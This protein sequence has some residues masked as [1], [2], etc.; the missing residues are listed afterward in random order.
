M[1]PG[2]ERHFVE[3]LERRLRGEPVAYLLGEREFWGRRFAVD[4]RVLIPRPESEHL[5]EIA[6][7]LAL[8]PRPRIVD[9]GTGSGCLAVTLALELD[10]ARVTAV[11]LSPA[12]LA[13]A[14]ANA[15]RL[16][17]R[18]AFCGGDLAGSLRL[19]TCDLLISNPPYV[20]PL[21]APSL[22]PEVSAFEPHLALFAA[23]GDAVIAHLLRQ[24][25]ALRPG[26]FAL[27]EI[28]LGQLA[29]VESR[30]PGSGLELV[31]ARPDLAGIPR[32]LLL[33]RRDG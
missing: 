2:A 6:L 21:D 26:A 3:L 17:A 7:A 10:G 12:A 16:G 14:A 11:D 25:R 33:R 18:V 15:R 29:R 28:G 24:A 32:A 27:L 30:L 20:D 23:G 19:D 8:P 5:V 4:A 9:L 22:S 31:E 1:A 13:V